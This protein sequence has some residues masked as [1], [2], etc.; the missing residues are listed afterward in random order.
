MPVAEE[1]QVTSIAPVSASQWVPA[2]HRQFTNRLINALPLA[3]YQRIASSL[4]LLTLKRGQTLYAHGEAQTH[5]YF[6][7]RGFWSLTR[8]MEDGSAVEVASVGNEGFIGV[9][10]ALG[11]TLA[12]GEARACITEQ[13]VLALPVAS[14]RQEMEER[15]IFS[16]VVRNYCE[17]FVGMILQGTACN[18]LHSAEARCCRW[19]LMAHDRVQRDELPVTHEMMAAA[20]GLRRPT[21]TMVFASLTRAGIVGHT[22]GRAFVLDRNGLEQ[23]SCECY[24]E[25]RKTFD[26]LLPRV[27]IGTD[28]PIG[29]T[30]RHRQTGRGDA[31][32]LREGN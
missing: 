14:F 29:E 1:N 5:V 30:A 24:R 27:G 17:A 3:N 4:T 13:S 16:Q 20:L 28:A 11:D 23:K 32:E 25:V 6:P 31:S 2:T 12:T 7:V 26:R 22:R 21:V 8:T 19:L 18:A 9:G 15:G 10:I